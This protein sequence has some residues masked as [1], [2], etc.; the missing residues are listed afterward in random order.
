[1]RHPT[2]CRPAPI[3]ARDELGVDRRTRLADDQPG[4]HAREQPSAVHAGPAG[5]G[6][7]V[8]SSVP[9]HLVGD[10][11]D[12]EDRRRWPRRSHSPRR[13]R[14]RASGRKICLVKDR[15]FRLK[16]HGF[17]RK[18][19]SLRWHDPDQV[20]RG[21]GRSLEQLPLS[22][23][24]RTPVLAESYVW[25]YA[26]RMDFRIFTEPQQGASYPTQ[27]AHRAGRRAARLRRLLP[28]RP[29]PAHGNGRLDG[30]PGPTDA[31]T[32]L[33]GLARETEPDPA[34]HPRLQRDLPA[35]GH[36]RDPGRRR[37]TRCRAAGS[38][39]GSAP[40]GSRRSTRAYGI[41]FPAKRFGLLEEQLEIVT[42]LWSTPVGETSVRG[43]ALPARGCPG[44]AEA[45]QPPMPIIVGGIGPT[46][47]PALA[48]RYATEFNIA[49]KD[50]ATIG[51]RFA[52]VRDAAGAIGRDPDSIVYSA[53]LTCAV[54]RSEADYRRRAEAIGRDPD[55]FRTTTSPAPPPRRWTRSAD[56]VSSA[57]TG[58]TCRSWTCTT[59]STS[60]SSPTRW[61][62]GSDR[63][64]LFV[65]SERTV[66][67]VMIAPPEV[68]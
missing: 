56:C 8:W 60:R 67:A 6:S 40:A 18:Q 3:T 21:H 47:T 68:G 42:G 16:R 17:G 46:R 58:S 66:G 11:P 61:S 7:S 53:A 62:P 54:G 38:S 63:S 55:T 28:Q 20:R 32:T 44:P 64:H 43:R 39:S 23:A 35:S 45:V 22:P 10:V 65:W 37:S 48:A 27:L 25:R 12:E 26:P 9:G 57:P 52:A 5:P 51:N 36:P 24:H 41:P 2:G 59:W 49:F 50:E 29:L 1:M 4:E 30:M 33:A 14:R 19:H 31:W 13:C 15:A 34:R